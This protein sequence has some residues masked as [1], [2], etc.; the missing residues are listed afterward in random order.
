[1]V[2]CSV[3][4]QLSCPNSAAL[5]FSSHCVFSAVSPLRTAGLV[6]R[7]PVRFQRLAAA[8]DCSMP[9]VSIRCWK[10]KTPTTKSSRSPE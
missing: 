6:A 8:P 9:W 1:M 4:F 7:A 10:A 2:N 3:T 5:V